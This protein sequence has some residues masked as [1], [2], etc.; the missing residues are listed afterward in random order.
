MKLSRASPEPQTTS[1]SFSKLRKH[2]TFD[3]SGYYH[4]QQ[5]AQRKRAKRQTAGALVTGL[6][7]QQAPVKLTPSGKK[8]TAQPRPAVTVQPRGIGPVMDP[9]DND[10][11]CGRGGRI[12]AHVGNIR[13]REMVVSRKKEYLSPATKKLEKA[14]IA[15]QVVQDIRA[16]DP[17][18]RFLKEDPDGSW[19]D[20]GDAKA[21]K[22]R[23][24]PAIT[25]VNSR[26]L[27]SKTNSPL[28]VLQSPESR[29]SFA[30][31]CIRG[32]Q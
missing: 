13:F 10:V 16:K 12:N 29:S 20:I 3:T 26:C 19:Y 31:R 25:D 24:L 4:A 14:H 30:R 15:A 18:G 7:G 11:L 8:S 2:A 21:I 17:P 32:S 23:K 5:N 22:V 1:S 28:C 9:N 6:L 27:Y